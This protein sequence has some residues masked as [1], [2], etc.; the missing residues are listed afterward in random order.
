MVL[1]PVNVLS[2]QDKQKSS[3]SAHNHCRSTA[4][5]WEN[6][7]GSGGHPKRCGTDLQRTVHFS[8]CLIDNKDETLPQKPLLKDKRV[9]NTPV[10]SQTIETYLKGSPTCWRLKQSKPVDIKPVNTDSYGIFYN[11]N[12]N[13]LVHYICLT[14]W[15]LTDTGLIWLISIQYNTML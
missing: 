6:L 2:P 13:C 8:N 15:V 7:T 5:G 1:K 14:W 4:H 12:S 11:S 9:M 10:P 3:I